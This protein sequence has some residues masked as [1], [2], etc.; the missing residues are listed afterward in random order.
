MSVFITRFIALFTLSCAALDAADAPPNVVII[1]ADDLGVECLSC[2][3]GTS[4]KTPNIDKLVTQS[5]RFTRCFSNPYCSPSR[6]SLLTGRYPFKNGLKTVLDTKQKEDVYLHPDQPS[7]ARELKQAGYATGLVGK[8]HMSL[9]HKHNTINEFGFDQYQTWRIFDDKGE[10]TTK[11]W[12]PYL[13][14]NGVVIADQIKERYGPDVDLEFYLDF[15]K[16]SVQKKQP[17]L[18]YYATCLP[19]FPWEPTP[20]SKD[21]SY[22]EKVIGKKGN[23]KYFPDMVAYL[24][25]QVGLIMKSLDD[26]KIADNTIVIFLADNGTDRDLVNTWGD[27]KQVK[28][29]KGTMTD[30][31]THVPLSVRWT[32]HIKAGSTCDNL[33]D[34]S[35]LFPTICDLTLT[36]RPK[37]EM[38]GRSFATQL[39]GNAGLPRE[40]IHIQ[41]ESARQVRNSDFMLDNKNQLRRVVELWED[42]AKPNE[43][44]NPEQEA[45]ARKS[46]QAV[47]DELK[48]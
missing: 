37:I 23:P 25:K 41:H 34:F 14:R 36:A 43:N 33:V 4:L 48:K 31:G 7:F 22:R 44:I 16:T 35:D 45:A 39:Y 2:Y 17:F 46:L 9:E 47:F 32:G 38:S 40:W 19:H 26:Q 28:G 15:I 1:L 18:A 6:A 3:G 30:R 24:D 42:P 21:Q 5:M 11:F 29:G 20:D 13:I 8:W 12:T 27:G 10:K